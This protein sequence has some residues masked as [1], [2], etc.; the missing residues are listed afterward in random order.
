MVLVVEALALRVDL[1][2]AFH[3]G[4]PGHE[5][6]LRDD[7]GAVALVAAQ[8]RQ[9]GAQAAPPGD[10]AAVVAHMPAKGG[11]GHGRQQFAHQR[12]VAAVAVAGQD[13]R[14]AGQVLQRAVGTLV[15]HA[16]DAVSARR[17]V[18]SGSRARCRHRCG[19]RAI[20]RRLRAFRDPDLAH[21]GLG[22]HVHAARRRHAAQG[23]EQGGACALGHAVDAVHAVAGVEPGVGH[24]EGDAMRLQRIDG[25]AHGLGVGQHQVRRG[26]A[27]ALGLDLAAEQR[28]RIRDAA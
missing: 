8:V 14:V 11:I 24:L 27:V 28:Q 4:G 20:Y 3:H 10:G 23:G 2:A 5:R 9:A 13:Q 6:A 15:R 26:L 17:R 7:P 12:G 1:H 21:Q 16:N 19:C 25:L 18:R 22:Q